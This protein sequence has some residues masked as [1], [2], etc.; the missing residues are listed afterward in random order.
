MIAVPAEARPWKVQTIAGKGA[1]LS[2]GV[3]VLPN[4]RTAVL[5]Q[6]RSSGRNR[7]EL[8]VGGSVRTL[9]LSSGSFDSTH[10]GHDSNGR[11]VVAW[12][13]LLNPGV[14]QAFAWTSRGGRQ[15]VSAVQKSVTDVTLAV[16]GNG[17][18]VLGFVAADGV[19][20]SRRSPGS[21]FAPAESLADAGTFASG[22]GVAVTRRGRIVAAW[23]R[24]AG[25]VARSASGAAPF[26][27][28]QA[29]ALRPAAAGATLVGGPPR[30]VITSQSR[31][32]V[33][34]S[35]YEL[36]R[37]AVTPL[38]VDQRVEAF[39]W[40]ASAAHPSA[41]ATLSR[42]ASAGVADVVAQGSSA[43]IAWTQ[44]AQSS[45]RELW[46][47]TWTA[48]GVQRPQIYNTR[49]LAA[50]VVLTAAAGSA[51]NVFYRAGGPRWF[52][53]RLSAAGRYS[54]TANVTP[55][56]EGVALIYAAASGNHVAAS[57]HAQLGP[58]AGSRRVQVA[59]P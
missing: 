17:R 22:P 46:A 29:V 3:D 53:V 14:A 8:R 54:G 37:T 33:V 20:V 1:A 4:G 45:P 38:F 44:K 57:W 40:P 41:S 13:R 42:S 47:T 11:L 58:T 5:L 50:P 28:A 55:A 52:N 24:G 9:D 27:A 6:R 25:V 15:Q 19:F 56:G 10:L 59:R 7:L 16:A 12:R 32:V 34:V 36:R 21:G 35:S 51:V 2:R 43:V 49:A 18:A 30:V 23:L 26:G 48:K 31:A 39:D